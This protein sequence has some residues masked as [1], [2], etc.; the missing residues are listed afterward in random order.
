MVGKNTA[1]IK[2]EGQVRGRSVSIHKTSFKKMDCINVEDK[3]EVIS[4]RVIK[5]FKKINYC[6]VGHERALC[7]CSLQIPQSLCLLEGGALVSVGAEVTLG[8]VQEE[9]VAEEKTE[10]VTEEETEVVAVEDEVVVL[11][12]GG[13]TTGLGQVISLAVSGQNSLILL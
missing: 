4:L 13:S 2:K 6:F 11:A 7:P 3:Y 1:C 10:V 8:I 9:V 5:K 12:G